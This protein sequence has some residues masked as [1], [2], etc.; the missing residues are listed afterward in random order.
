MSSVRIC[1][2]QNKEIFDAISHFSPTKFP[3]IVE[4]V[5]NSEELG[6]KNVCILQEL[7]VEH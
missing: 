1:F 4:M 5:D 6:G 3:S 7:H 2:E